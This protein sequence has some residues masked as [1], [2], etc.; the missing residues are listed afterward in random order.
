M[1]RAVVT[2]ATGFVGLNLLRVL[3]DRG[4]DVVALHRPSSDLSWL[5]RIGAGDVERRIAD[6]TDAAAVL[7]AMPAA[8]D[9]VFH[10]AASTNM[11]SRRNAEQ[12]RINVD[13]T[14]HV[15]RAALERGARRLVHTSSIAAFGIHE[16]TIDETTP[17]NAR[18]SWVN[19]LRTKA[20]GEDEVR[21]GIADGLDAVIVN[22][23]SILGP[24]DLGSWSRMFRLVHDER[25]P[26]VP[27]GRGSF[28]H[29]RDVV[30][31]HVAAAERGRTGEN[32][33]LGGADATY[34]E[35]VQEIGRAADRRVPQKP[36]PAWVLR[37]VA[38]AQDWRARLGGRRP[39][40]TPESVELVCRRMTCRS[41]KAVREL[42]YRSRP[43][44]AM[45]EDCYG[46][47]R[48]AGRLASV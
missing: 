19:Y 16:G 40:V 6:V 11:W 39:V 12:T 5:E 10:V 42:D 43:L 36:T 48:E 17:S 34:L 33:L 41:D 4:F 7:R 28:C 8:P 21:A 18:T 26:G 44:A 3:C 27:P 15:V 9:V 37:S 20:L 23:A 1:P 32:Y 24:Y 46:W 14:R 2:G 22:P 35:L 31:A 29:V 45:V 25:L 30:D 38:R 47:M 13:G